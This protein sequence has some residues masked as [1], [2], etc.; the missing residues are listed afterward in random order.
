MDCF[1]SR[2]SLIEVDNEDRDEP[3]IEDSESDSEHESYTLVKNKQTKK[4]TLGSC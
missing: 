4:S 3:E 2:L 1:V